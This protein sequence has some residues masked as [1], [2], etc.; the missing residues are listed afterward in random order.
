MFLEN[1]DKMTAG[2]GYAGMF[3]THDLTCL[4][5]VSIDVGAGVIVGPNRGA[6]EGDPSKYSA[7]TRVA[8]NLG[9]HP[10]VGIRGSITTLRACGNGGIPTQLHLA[11]EDRIHAPVIH[12]Q[13]DQVRAFSADLESYTAAFQSV[14]RGSA[15]SAT[16][17]LS[18]AA[19]HRAASIVR[20]D[21]ESQFFD[22]WDNNDA[23]G[24]VQ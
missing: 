16:E 9:S 5:G 24:L 14:H 10:S 22:G 12:D 15:P 7:G 18:L 1:V 17:V 4:H 11:A 13:Q 19:N 23:L 21:S 8:K 20:A 3:A 2:L 6:F